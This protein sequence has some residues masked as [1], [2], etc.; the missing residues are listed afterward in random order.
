[1]A[2]TC[3]TGL[4]CTPCGSTFRVDAKT[5][6]L[7]TLQCIDFRFRDSLPCV[8]SRMGYRDQHDDVILA[9]SSL[10]YNGLSGTTN[11]AWVTTIDEQIKIA[12]SL[13]QISEIFLID[14]MGC[15]AYAVNYPGLTLNTPEEYNLHVE[16][17]NITEVKIKEK[18]QGPTATIMEIPNLV[19]KKYVIGIYGAYMADVDVFPGTMPLASP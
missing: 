16:N 11:A 1:M 9:G 13:H 8:L 2:S 6:K 5:C 10:G 18:F 3:P 12:Y 4:I 14:H 15:G 17:L 7:L 19:I